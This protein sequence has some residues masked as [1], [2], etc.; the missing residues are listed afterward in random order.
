MVENS[1]T[2]VI[3]KRLLV[4]GSPNFSVNA[5]FMFMVWLNIPYYFNHPEYQTLEDDIDTIIWFLVFAVNL[6][7][8]LVR[9]W[10]KW[11]Y[12]VFGCVIESPEAI[13]PDEG[14]KMVGIAVWLVLAVIIFGLAST[15]PA[16]YQFEIPEYFGT[17]MWLV[18][19]LV[20]ASGLK[21]EITTLSRLSAEQKND[22]RIGIG[23]YVSEI[24][25]KNRI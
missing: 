5:W 21:F 24:A 10:L 20:L 19:S 16:K 13:K 6:L 4:G 23:I 1:D 22:L 7:V 12:Q 2:G 15:I 3:D 25:P 11:K 9:I 14:D 18:F 17:A 8:I